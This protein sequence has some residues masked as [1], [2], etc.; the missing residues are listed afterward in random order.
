MIRSFADR[1]TERLFRREWVRRWGATLQRAGL[2]TLVT[3]DAA[4]TL[5]DLVQTPGNRLEKLRGDRAGQWSIR[6]NAQWRV[7]F[8]WAPD[9]P[10]EV[11]MVD[12]HGGQRR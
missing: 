10:H 1:D 2:Q 7:C 3:L 6:V 9:G 12:Y 11:E 5:E 4:V 8:R